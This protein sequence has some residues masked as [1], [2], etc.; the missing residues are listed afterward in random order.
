MGFNIGKFLGGAVPFVG[1]ALDALSQHSA[2][3]TNRR[4]ANQQMAFQERMSSTEMQRRVADLKAAGLNPM[5]AGMNQQGASSAQGATTRV[6][7]ITRNTA[8]TALAATMQRQQLE[9]MEAQTGL[10]REQTRTAAAEATMKEHQ[11]PWSSQN[12]YEN[13][14][15]LEQG[16]KNLAL[17]GQ[18]LLNELDIQT[19]DIRNKR[20]TNAQ[21]ERLQPL[22]LEYQRLINAGEKLG[23]S[24][25][26]VDAQFAEQM[27]TD[28]K[29]LR[30][31]KELIR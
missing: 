18:K 10:L 17:Q 2:N 7:P 16:T 25:K 19:E 20:L 9:N 14:K 30:L 24:E 21:L 8:S 29:F 1:A 15:Q 27:G 5:L 28:T 11:V 4:I 31:I 26:Q 6:E 3:S 23:L 13:A 12:V 22:L